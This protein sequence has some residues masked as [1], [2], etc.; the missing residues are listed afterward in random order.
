M[1]NKG[2]RLGM[3]DATFVVN[4]SISTFK[5]C[6]TQRVLSFNVGPPLEVDVV[7]KQTQPLARGFP[8]SF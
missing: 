2:S 5:P 4:F 1:Q 3:L 6:N 8:Y 7:M